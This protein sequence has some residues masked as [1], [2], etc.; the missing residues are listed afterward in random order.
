MIDTRGDTG[1]TTTNL[2]EKKMK[3]AKS[4][5]FINVTMNYYFCRLPFF[6]FLFLHSVCTIPNL[7]LQSFDGEYYTAI[8]FARELYSLDDFNSKQWQCNFSFRFIIFIISPLLSRFVLRSQVSFCHEKISL[9]FS[10]SSYS[11][12]SGILVFFAI[13]DIMG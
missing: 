13:N 1:T 10:F 4:L 8:L 2:R 5:I 3:R 11:D 6:F 7:L 12:D 9:R